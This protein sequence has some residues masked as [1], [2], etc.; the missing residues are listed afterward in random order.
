[1]THGTDDAPV[2]GRQRLA[3][4]AFMV[5]GLGLV[6]H[7]VV[8]LPLWITVPGGLVLVVALLA[9][10][11]ALT[12]LDLRPVLVPGA[13]AGVLATVA[14]DLSRIAAVKVLGSDLQPFEAWRFFGAA[15]VGESASLTARWAAG[16]L[17]HVINGVAFALAYTVWF[18]R[19]GPVAGIAWGLF[20]EAFMLGL[21]PGWLVIS[22]YRPFLAVSLIGHVAYGATLGV[23][24]RALLRRG[25]RAGPTPDAL[26][27]RGGGADGG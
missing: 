25:D 3:G 27:V 12:G 17:F 2:R 11:G 1:M 15:L 21:Y 18:G 4:A 22:A 10:V 19:R 20:L 7:I 13:T 14:Y 16:G 9:W 26:R 5:S 24:A 6:V 8:G 23:T